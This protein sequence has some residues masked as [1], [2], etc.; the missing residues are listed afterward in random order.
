MMD[1]NTEP[2]SRRYAPVGSLN[3]GTEALMPDPEFHVVGFKASLSV[4][5]DSDVDSE[6]ARSPP[7]TAKGRRRCRRKVAAGVGEGSPET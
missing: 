1:S 6:L 2:R 3:L 7:V 5:K 4:E